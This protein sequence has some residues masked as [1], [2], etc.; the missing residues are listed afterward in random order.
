MLGTQFTAPMMYG[1]AALNPGVSLEGWVGDVVPKGFAAVLKTSNFALAGAAG[2]AAYATG[3]DM[4]CSSRHHRRQGV[5]TA[6]LPRGVPMPA[7]AVVR[8]TCWPELV[9][10]S[11]AARLRTLHSASDPLSASERRR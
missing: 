6:V 4:A 8:L 1:L 9:V 10:V 3:S 5:T 11:G 7:D 2:V